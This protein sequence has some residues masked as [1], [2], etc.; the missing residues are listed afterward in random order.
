MARAN[1]DTLTV[2]A[3]ERRGET[4]AD[5]MIVARDE[6]TLKRQMAQQRRQAREA[7]RA[8]TGLAL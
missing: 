5:Q 1:L 3:G 8:V 6:I 2:P 4:F 7:E